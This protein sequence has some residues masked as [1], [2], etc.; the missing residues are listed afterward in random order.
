MMAPTR[1]GEGESFT[2]PD[3][4]EAYIVG[5]GMTPFARHLDRTHND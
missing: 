5:V 3:M 2:M 4:R 1:P